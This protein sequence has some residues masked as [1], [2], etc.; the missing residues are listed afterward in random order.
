[1]VVGDDVSLLVPDKAGARTTWRNFAAAEH[2]NTS[3][4]R[5]D[6]DNGRARVLEEVDDRLLIGAKVGVGD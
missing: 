2:V 6:I 1:M 4:E 5:A 3:R